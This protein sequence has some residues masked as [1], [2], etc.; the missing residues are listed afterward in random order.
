MNLVG[1]RTIIFNVL[2]VIFYYAHR[3]GWIP[4]M[5]EHAMV[6]AG[7]DILL[8]NIPALWAAGNVWL[9]FLTKGPVGEKPNA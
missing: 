3:A 2:M 7:I 6:Y 5:P 1:Y 8:N 9:R 4:S